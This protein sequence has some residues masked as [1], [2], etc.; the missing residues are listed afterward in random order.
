MC[1]S[2]PFLGFLEDEGFSPHWMACLKFKNWCA[3]AY[4][5]ALPFFV[6]CVPLTWTLAGTLIVTTL[7]CLSFSS[8]SFTLVRHHA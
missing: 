8:L 2:G 4:I 6:L 7:E 5:I 3:I 1:R